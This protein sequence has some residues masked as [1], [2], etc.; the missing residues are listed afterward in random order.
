M[1]A[2]ERLLEMGKAL[3]RAEAQVSD[4]EEQLKAAK[5]DRDRLALED[6]PALADELGL[7]DGTFTMQDGRRLELKRDVSARIPERN[8]EAAMDWLRRH[9]FSGLIKTQVVANFNRG[10]NERAKH[11]VDRVAAEHDDVQMKEV[12]HPQT[13]KAFVR[14]R[15]AAGEDFPWEIFGAHPFMKAEVK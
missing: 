1:N 7:R 14:E 15:M 6:I 10:D 8:R 13:L 4:L 11:I 3:Q 2:T 5:R 9:N 12:V